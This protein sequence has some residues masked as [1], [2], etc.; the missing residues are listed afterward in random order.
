MAKAKVEEEVSSSLESSSSSSDSDSS[1]SSSSSG[2][3][4]TSDFCKFMKFIGILSSHFCIC[5]IFFSVKNQK[6]SYSLRLFHN[7]V[8]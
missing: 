4:S 8:L 2:S 5:F 7:L 1:D 3:D 6:V